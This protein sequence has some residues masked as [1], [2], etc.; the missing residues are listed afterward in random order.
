M[1]RNYC[2]LN[3]F[4]DGGL[5][6][7]RNIH[8]KNGKIKFGWKCTMCMRCI[9]YCPQ[10]AITAGLIEPL[11]IHGAYDF[12]RILNDSSIPSDY[13]LNCKKGFFKHF[14]KYA[15]EIEALKIE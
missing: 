13:I 14:R 8:L 9:M 6:E 1:I 2:S 4:V 5:Y 11:A 10:K 15:R 3:I 7:K 12:K